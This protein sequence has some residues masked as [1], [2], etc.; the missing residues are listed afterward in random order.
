MSRFG[1]A[2]ASGVGGILSSVASSYDTK[3][4]AEAE[5]KLLAKRAE[6]DLNRARVI[7][8][9]Q[10]EFAVRGETRKRESAEKM[11]RDIDAEVGSR[12]SRRDAADIAKVDDPELK[13]L[14][15]EEL[16]QMRADPKAREKFGIL[17]APTR[18]EELET[19]ASAANKLGYTD[20]AKEARAE[21]QTEIQNDR[22]K[23][24]D[25]NADADRVDNKEYRSST[26][27]LQ[28]KQI[29]ATIAHNN[30]MASIAA[31]RTDAEKLSPAAKLQLEVASTG[32]NAA[33]R[34]ESEAAKAVDAA[35]KRMGSVDAFDE[36]GKKSAEAALADAKREYSASKKGVQ[37]ALKVYTATGKAHLGDD[38]KEIVI[39]KP[40]PSAED[41]ARLKANPDKASDF[42]AHFDTSGG[43]ASSFLKKEE[44]K[45]EARGILAAPKPEAP[46]S[47]QAKQAAKAVPSDDDK[48]LPGERSRMMARDGMDKALQAKAKE[49]AAATN[50]GDKAAEKRINEEFMELSRAKQGMM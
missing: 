49:L 37:Q 10:E 32:V 42:D 35:Q 44:K 22:N 43:A 5:E 25:A 34:S 18:M 21:L 12:M 38:F 4:K 23:R 47:E 20:A 45:P 14:T 26:L 36:T 24:T 2:L 33:Q 27:A 19:R 31:R 28:E 41:I 6:M 39:D 1:N 9:M 3:I 40:K 50:R 15:R 13:N 7:A 48:M 29:N 17:S 46:K 16:A 8:E 30:K 11:G